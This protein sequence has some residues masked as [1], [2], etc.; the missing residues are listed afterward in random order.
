M[1]TENRVENGSLHPGAVKHVPRH[2]WCRYDVASNAVFAQLQK[3][4]WILIHPSPVAKYISTRNAIMSFNR[5]MAFVQA[6]KR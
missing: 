4:S 1:R 6:P 3:L 5:R 2:G